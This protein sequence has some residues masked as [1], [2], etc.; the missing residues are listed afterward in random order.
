MI[1][2]IAN[3]IA[4]IASILMVYSGLL[5]EKRK[6]LFV[7]SIHIALFVV[8]NT[9]LKGISGVIINILS[10][11][12]NILCYNNK[13]NLAVKILLTVITIPV[14]IYFNNRGII[15]LLPLVAALLFLWL[16]TIKDVKKFKLLMIVTTAMWGIY[17]FYIQSYTSF[18]F[19]ILT[20]A[21]NIISIIKMRKRGKR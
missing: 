9:L 4:L 15:G 7:H 1:I 14:T 16:M 12:R 21:A 8:S 10:F 20:I 3:I 18:V 19:D 6:I 17:E 11:I 13:L 5:K 2:V